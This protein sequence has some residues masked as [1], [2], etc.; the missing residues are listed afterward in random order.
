MSKPPRAFCKWLVQEFGDDDFAAGEYL[1][2][3]ASQNPSSDNLVWELVD[4][5]DFDCNG[6][7]NAFE[8]GAKKAFKIAEET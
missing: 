2:Y 1:K 4:M 3:L 6:E 5:G 8:N 7:N